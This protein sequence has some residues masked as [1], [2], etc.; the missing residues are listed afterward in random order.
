ME[1]KKENFSEEEI[2]E[3]KLKQKRIQVV[4]DYAL[5]VIKTKE[6]LTLFEAEKIVEEVKKYA[7]K[8][9]PDKEETFN[10]IYLPRFEREIK[11]RFNLS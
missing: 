1:E 11:K 8:L 4:C 10:I 2:R 3:D 9:F 6:G 7:L 5:F